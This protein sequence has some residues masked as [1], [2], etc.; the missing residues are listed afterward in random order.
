MMR[1]GTPSLVQ[2][3]CPYGPCLQHSSSALR[4][5]RPRPMLQSSAGAH[6]SGVWPL[7]SPDIAEQVDNIAQQVDSLFTKQIEEWSKQEG[8]SQET[9]AYL[10]SGLGEA[11]PGLDPQFF[12]WLAS[13][14]IG[15]GYIRLYLRLDGKDVDKALVT[16]KRNLAEA[17]VL[18]VNAQDQ[19]NTNTV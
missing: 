12:Q 18:V 5:Q 10:A 14:V 9:L 13:R 1:L 4:K 8:L 6:A 17:V 16:R 3:R 2:A 11:K 7:L 15:G 19:E